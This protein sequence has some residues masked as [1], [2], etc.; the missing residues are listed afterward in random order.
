MIAPMVAVRNPAEYI[1]SLTHLEPD[2]LIGAGEA[3]AYGA[4]WWH[5]PVATEVR[6]LE[7]HALALHLAGSTLVEKWCEG[8]HKGHRSRIGSISLVPAHVHSTWVLDG[9]SH[10]A[11]LYVD[12]GRLARAAEEHAPGTAA[13]AD[14]FAEDDSTS[15]ALVRRM[16]LQTRLGTFDA[17]AHDELMAQLLPHLV[18]RY[19]LDRPP[20]APRAR[21][22]LTGATLKRLFAHV[23]ERLSEP[24]RLSEMAALAR[25]SEDHFL[26]AFK[27]AVGQT[28]HQYV[29]QRRLAYAQRLLA[30]TDVPVAHV[31]RAGGFRGASHFSAVFRQHVGVTPTTWRRSRR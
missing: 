30:T 16:L 24:L 31:A 7:Q 23:E 5:A 20:P 10:V 29:V 18:R 2:L 17:L 4:V 27:L 21:L 1:G 8:H 13:L 14:F 26:R 3:T 6:G 11:H 19:P 15:A 12:P 25:L 28:P 9:W 22:T